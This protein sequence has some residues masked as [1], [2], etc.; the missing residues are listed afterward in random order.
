M[1]S[2]PDVG[3]ALLSDTGDFEFEASPT[4]EAL[5]KLLGELIVG[6]PDERDGAPITANPVN[7]VGAAFSNDTFAL[8]SYCWCE[9]NCHPVWCPPNFHH[10]PSDLK[11]A[12]YKR[13]GRGTSQSAKLDVRQEVA[14][15]A[16]CI[17]SIRRQWGRS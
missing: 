11:V 16:D 1:T 5:I 6:A 10:F 4:V 8:R 17:E 14:V 12:W 3:Q 7:N 15:A 9:G 13:L 2:E